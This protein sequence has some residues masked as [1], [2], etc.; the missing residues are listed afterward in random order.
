MLSYGDVGAGQPAWWRLVAWRVP[1]RF[2]VGS[3]N[4]VGFTLG[5]RR[6]AAGPR[7][8]AQSSA[9]PITPHDV[10]GGV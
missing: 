6:S 5:G 4:E 8:V 9:G 10:P 3:Q 7:D 2:L 1:L